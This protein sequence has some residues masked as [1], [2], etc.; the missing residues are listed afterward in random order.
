[1]NIFCKPPGQKSVH[2]N[3]YYV[4]TAP[5]WPLILNTTTKINFG[6]GLEMN[7]NMHRIAYPCRTYMV[8]VAHAILNT[9]K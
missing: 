2:D 1:M 7:G 4:D 9:V 3:K 6:A 5:A 8:G